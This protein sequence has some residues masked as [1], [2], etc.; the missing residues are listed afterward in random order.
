[1]SRKQP[2]EATLASVR[3]AL[4]AAQQRRLTEAATKPAVP[5]VT[6]SRQA[7]A[8]GN[9]FARRLADRLNERDPGPPPWT[10]WDR[11]LVEKVVAEQGIPEGLVESLE[12][13]GR[14]WLEQFLAGLSDADRA[15]IL[16][17]P[18]VYRRVAR[19]IRGL[20]RAG[21]TIIVGR[22]GVYSAADLPGGVHVRLV[23]PFDQRVAH[24][25]E[26][27][28][29]PAAQAAAEVR[30]LDHDRDAFHR[31]HCRGNAP[32]PEIFTITLNVAAMSDEQMVECVLPLVPIR[33]SPAKA[34]DPARQALEHV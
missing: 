17:E 30:R 6:I 10:V 20:A 29:L 24:L 3:A 12:T 13:P 2:L 5:F 11:E 18:M 23:A 31:R 32:L 14:P 4:Y 25:A 15:S 33:D 21:K 19:T 9:T 8:R 1:M 27:R 26:L 22:G 28:D 7:G 34:S 16:D